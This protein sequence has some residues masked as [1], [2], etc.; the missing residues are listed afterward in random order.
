MTWST[1]LALGLHRQHLSFKIVILLLYPTTPPT[2]SLR[3]GKKK[4]EKLCKWMLDS[5]DAQGPRDMLFLLLQAFK[6]MYFQHFVLELL[7]E[8]WS[9]GIFSNSSPWEQKETNPRYFNMAH[10]VLLLPKG[11]A[12]LKC[13]EYVSNSWLERSDLVIPVRF[14]MVSCLLLKTL[15]WSFSAWEVFVVSWICNLHS[16]HFF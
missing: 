5:W 16:A 12:L 13:Q 15:P 9:P 8:F 1:P 3:V 11:S 4:L 10:T 7:L 2:L 6:K 14:L